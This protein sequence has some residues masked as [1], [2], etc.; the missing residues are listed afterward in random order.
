MTIRLNTD[1]YGWSDLVPALCY[2]RLKRLLLSSSGFSKNFSC[3]LA[4]RPT[5][6]L[7]CVSNRFRESSPSFRFKTWK[8]SGANCDFDQDH[9][10]LCNF[11]IWN[12]DST[13]VLWFGWR[14]EGS[15]E[16]FINGHDGGGRK[17][18]G[19]VGGWLVCTLGMNG[20]GNGNAISVCIVVLGSHLRVA[21]L[22]Q[23]IWQWWKISII[24]RDAKTMINNACRFQYSNRRVKDWLEAILLYIDYSRAA[25]IIRSQIT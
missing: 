14:L 22:K 2:A 23:M 11:R 12:V 4:T 1:E 16:L 24:P 25:V 17:G 3:P 18:D 7:I 8:F 21:Q 9:Q 15:F 5:S 19:G 6:F 13:V 10:A 20:I